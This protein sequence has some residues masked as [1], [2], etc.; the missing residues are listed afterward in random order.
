MRPDAAGRRIGHRRARSA[1]GHVV[2]H[3]RR[4]SRTPTCDRVASTRR[5]LARLPH[6]AR[7]ADAARRPGRRR[8]HA[9]RAPRPAA[10]ADK[11]DRAAQDLR[12][13]GGDRDRERAPVQRDQGGAGAADRHRRGAAGHQ[14]FGRRHRSRC[15]TKILESCQHAVRRPQPVVF[16]RRR[17]AA[18]CTLARSP[19]RRRRRPR[20][21]PAAPLDR[22]LAAALAIA[23]VRA[24]GRARSSR[25]RRAG[26]RRTFRRV[27]RWRASGWATTRMLSRRCC[28]KAAAS[29]RSLCRANPPRPSPT[30]RSTL[31]QTFADQAV[32]AIENAR[33]FN[34]TKE[35]LEQQTAT[36]EVLQVISSSVGRR[37][38]GVRR[39]PRRAASTLF[40]SAQL[41]IVPGRRRTSCVALA[42]PRTAPALRRAATR[43]FPLPLGRRSLPARAIRERRA[44]HVADVL[45]DADAARTR[46]QRGRALRRQ[47]L[48][49]LA[50]MLW[51][52]RGIGSLVRDARSQ[53]GRSPT[54][55][56]RCCKTFADQAVIAIQNARLFNETK[57]ALEQQT[58]TA[59]V[60]QVISSSV[61]DTAAGVRQDPRELPAP[62]RRRR[63][64][65]ACWST[66]T[67]MLH[68]R[69]V[70]GHGAR[71][72]VAAHLPARRSSATRRP[73][74]RSASGA[75]CTIP[76]C[77]NGTDVPPA[78]CAELAQ[79]RRQLLGGCSRRCCGRT[80]ASARSAS[81]RSRRG[82]SRD[83]EI[84]LLQDLRRPGGDRDRERAA[85]QRDEGGAGAADR[86]GRG[87]AGDQQLDGRHRSR[88]STRS[89]TAASTCSRSEQLGILLL[90]DDGHGASR[91]V[92]RR[93]RCDAHAQRRSPMPLDQTITARVDPRRGVTLHVPDAAAMPRCA[94]RMR[95]GW[96]SSS[97]TTRSPVVADAV[98]GPRHRLDLRAAPAA[99][100]RSPTRRSRCSR[101]SPT[102][103]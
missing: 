20:S 56:S 18:C 102:R 51:E 41:G 54:R 61:A 46:A 32:I 4:R 53:P 6:G 34:E 9:W 47:L 78:C 22:D 26:R 76:T 94:G 66:T 77:C 17:R 7:R 89:S 28:G 91:R 73:A 5:E 13:P 31:L 96:P 35:A 79:A 33:L 97:A 87:A 101:P 84:A 90:G 63:A 85:V 42:R 67:G 69:R 60:L 86:H 98:G 39:D 52:G 43:I 12:R 50:P 68:V 40:D 45:D 74:A 100:R 55:R 81:A 15:S 92:A 70:L 72:R 21:S 19:R 30:R 71:S 64:R 3:R 49:C 10:F 27:R 1:S 16:L 29:A 2:Q 48:A 82:R 38:A 83:K 95:D 99:A 57:E 36:A 11:R 93:R 75:C 59:E 80:A 37:A 25:R 24:L 23:T 58:A 88:C 8:D 65:R 44:V 103:R 62:V 14:Q